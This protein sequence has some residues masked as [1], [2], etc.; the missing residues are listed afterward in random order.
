MS[1]TRVFCR[2]HKASPS[3]ETIL[4]PL[5]R[6]EVRQ[7]WFIE[8]AVMRFRSRRGVDPGSRDR[9]LCVELDKGSDSPQEKVQVRAQVV[10]EIKPPVWLSIGRLVWN[11]TGRLN[12]VG[13]S[14]MGL[15]CLVVLQR[16]PASI[17][18]SARVILH[19][20]VCYSRRP[21]T[22]NIY[23]GRSP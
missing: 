13:V 15:R 10:H 17:T 9:S 5:C 8:L 4:L 3:V 14:G 1:D 21:C 22:R 16:K 11:M 19:V 20:T 7:P 12:G 23:R 18:S 2:I 6:D